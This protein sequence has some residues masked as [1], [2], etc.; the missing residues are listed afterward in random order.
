MVSMETISEPML[1]SV[2]SALVRR[3]QHGEF[4]QVCI[5]PQNYFLRLLNRCWR[6]RMS[7]DHVLSIREHSPNISI[8]ED[9]LISG[10][11][12]LIARH[13]FGNAVIDDPE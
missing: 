1:D 8:F 13:D 10:H 4:G 11:V 12:S 7:G 5:G 3:S 9:A 6:A 2:I